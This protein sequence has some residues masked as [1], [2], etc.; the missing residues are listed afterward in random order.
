MISDAIDFQDE[1]DGLIGP[2]EHFGLTSSVMSAEVCEFLSVSE[3]VIQDP[4]SVKRRKM[5]TKRQVNLEC[6]LT[7]SQIR[8]FA[9]KKSSLM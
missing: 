7:K 5:K 6:F 8:S 9:I 3:K 1:T 4:E 2:P